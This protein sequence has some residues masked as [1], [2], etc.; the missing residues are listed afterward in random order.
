MPR[1]RSKPF[2][3][4]A[5]VRCNCGKS[6]TFK[7]QSQYYEA[8]QK[9]W[10]CKSCR[11]RSGWSDADKKKQSKRL[12]KH[13]GTEPRDPIVRKD[14][15]FKKWRKEVWKRDNYSCVYCGSNKNLNAHHILSVSKHFDFALFINNGIT[16]CVSC[17]KA[18]HQ[19]NGI[20]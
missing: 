16:L 20:I 12:H 8:I 19:L 4:D 17:H 1:R 11:P 3:E 15:S 6:H 13:Y 2:V 14:L 10:K 7:K 9:K 18:E 5:T